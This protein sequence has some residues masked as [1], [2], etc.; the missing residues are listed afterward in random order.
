MASIDKTYT[1]NY[2]EYKK[3]KD[4][5]DKQIVTF[6]DGSTQC[7][8]DWVFS[9]ER[10]DFD[11]GE[12]PIMNSPR[13]LDAYLI[14]NCKIDFVILRLK[15]VYKNT[16]YK[17]LETTNLSSVPKGY[18][19][20]RK[21]VIQN[22]KNCKFP[23]YKKMW[24]KPFG[25]KSNWWLQS[26]SNFWFCSATKTWVH[27]DDCYPHETNTAN[28]KSTKALIR[29]LRKQYLPGGITFSL[30][31]MYKGEYYNVIIK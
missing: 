6:F 17:Q 20:N 10:K 23:F 30:R 12:I 29:Q 25:G 4:W 15:E 18:S 9:Y 16:T 26:N 2:N 19:K 7:I 11:Y 13:W 3:F 21:I 24:K 31:G 5:S 22:S 28:P 1:D 27:T 8:G 14:Q